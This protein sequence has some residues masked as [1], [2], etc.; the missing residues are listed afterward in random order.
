VQAGEIHEA[1]AAGN[2]NKVQSIITAD[3]GSIELK[4][5]SGCTP[6]SIACLRNQVAVANFLIDKGANVNARNNWGQTPLHNANGV[7]GQ[8]FDLIKRLIAKG[9][10]VNAQGN[11]GDTPLEWAAARGNVKVAKL[12]IESGADLNAHDKNFGT[13]LHNTIG[14]GGR[15][16]AKLL[17]ESGAKLNQKDP[18][19]YTEI[20]LAAIHGDADLVRPLLKHGADV[21]A[22]DGHGRTALYYAAK[23]GYRGVAGALIAGGAKKSAIVESNYGKAP[24]LAGTFKDGEAYLWFLGGFAGDGYALKTKGH[25]LL[26]DPPGIGKSPEA[27]LI[28]GQL[29]P[30]ELAGQK[31]TVLISKPDWE[32]YELGV[33]A[34][35]KRMAGVDIVISYKP[36]AKLASEGTVPSYRL[37]M[38]DQTLSMG[39]LK[40][41]VIPATLGGV[42]YFVEADG[43]KIF[44]AGYHVCNEASRVENYRKEID[45]LKP[46]GPIDVVVL[47]VA[48]HL[49]ES[50]TY[51]SY[52]YLLDQLSPKAVYLM[53]GNYIPEE[54]SKC[55]EIL[56]TRHVPVAYPE[57]EGDRFH[58][59][60]D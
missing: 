4:D 27:G 22:V 21:N 54:Y 24:Q 12:L 34:L 36:E 6:L 47:P 53:H 20:H 41:H 14:Q 26:F 9:A 48:G 30:S 23:H 58:F 10:D 8:D 18:S 56:R 49:V 39:D 35:A 57:N 37:A 40:V 38:P 33:F 46:F 32:R 19:G 3:P 45:F 28:N 13:I 15:E 25:L 59:L 5:E 31:I 60:R 55:A 11:R 50:F 29:N 52:I 16:M 42:G 44:Y 1:A 7:F 17:I 2:L 51:D 43:L